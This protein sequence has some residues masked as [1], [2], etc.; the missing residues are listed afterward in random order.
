[1]LV[2]MGRAVSAEDSTK[3]KDQK[4]KM[5]HTSSRVADMTW[6]IR[7]VERDEYKKPKRIDWI[8]QELWPLWLLL[9]RKWKAL[10]GLCGIIYTKSWQYKAKSILR[11]IA[12]NSFWLVQGRQ[13]QQIFLGGNDNWS[14]SCL[15]IKLLPIIQ[16]P[17]KCH[18]HHTVPTSSAYFYFITLYI[19]NMF[20]S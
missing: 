16:N 9:L 7:R 3:T 6:M 12:S 11:P 5:L 13:R 20:L 1:M 8:N 14:D 2:F 15:P 18:L 17:P 10:G 4:W 19:C